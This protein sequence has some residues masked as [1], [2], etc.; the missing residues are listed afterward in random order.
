[1]INNADT[2]VKMI[3]FLTKIQNVYIHLNL[4]QFE[5]NKTFD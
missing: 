4:E 3:L 5:L 2:I 1:M